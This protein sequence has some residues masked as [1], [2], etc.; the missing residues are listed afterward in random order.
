MPEFLPTHISGCQVWLDASDLNYLFS[1]KD[2]SFPVSVDGD[3]VGY[4]GDK[5]GND[6]NFTN[7]Y[8]SESNRPIYVESAYHSKPAIRFNGTS[9]YLTL[10]TPRENIEQTVFIVASKPENAGATNQRLLTQTRQVSTLDYSR[11]YAPFVVQP[12]TRTLASTIDSNTVY[13]GA[14]NFSSIQSPEEFSIFCDRVTQTNYN[15]IRNGKFTSAAAGTLSFRVSSS[16]TRMG[17]NIANSFSGTTSGNYFAGDVSEL[18]IYNRYL[19]NDERHIVEYYLANKWN[20]YDANYICAIKN[21]NWSDYLTWSASAVPTQNTQVYS[22]NFSVEIDQN[23]NVPILSNATLSPLVSGSNGK[24]LLNNPYS[25]LTSP[26]GIIGS[27]DH[28]LISNLSGLTYSISGNFTGPV[29][30][31]NGSELDLTVYGNVRATTTKNCI[32]LDNENCNLTIYGNVTGGD[33]V[34]GV[35][36]LNSSYIKVYGNVYGGTNTNGHGL[37]IEN[38]KFY[39]Y[40]NVYAG[41]TYNG[42]CHGISA[43]ETLGTP[44]IFVYGNIYGTTAYGLKLFQNGNLELNGDAVA[45]NQWAAINSSTFLL[46]NITINGSLIHGPNGTQPIYAPTYFVKPAIYNSTTLNP[47]NSLVNLTTYSND[48]VAGGYVATRSTIRPNFSECPLPGVSASFIAEDTST[49]THYI[50]KTYTAYLNSFFNTFLTIYAKKQG[51]QYISLYLGEVSPSNLRYSKAIFDLENGVV[52]DMNNYTSAGVTRRQALTGMESVG[53]GWYRC[54]L[55][56]PF[57]QAEVTVHIAPSNVP[58]FASTTQSVVS[59]TG[60][61]LSGVLICGLHIYPGLSAIDGM[62]YTT[63]PYVSTGNA[64]GYYNIYTNDSVDFFYPD[65]YKLNYVPQASSV[66]IGTIYGGLTSLNN[67]EITIVETLTGTM[68]IPNSVTVAY[69]VPVGD[70]VGSAMLSKETLLNIWKSDVSSLT[71]NDGL[72]TRLAKTLTNAQ[73]GETMQSLDNL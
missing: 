2:G 51:R 18:I 4:W 41:R 58:K 5:S 69:G 27:T 63:I 17:A 71:A 52:T 64:P 36:N 13:T 72:F 44:N 12:N 16:M 50:G 9:S 40:G 66:E 3:P 47:N 21:G 57:T 23:I 1:F 30:F 42:T 37:R 6:L 8:A 67:E 28:C 46:N 25:I 73:A 32:E 38:G 59:Y 10:G 20:V 15:N 53:D 19:T 33:T 54:I 61:T 31:Q 11:G 43:G 62:D 45:T 29:L 7:D 14:I 56:C 48:F 39:I 55:E 70:T 22:N 34:S 65:S 24:F 68:V 60:N 49:N 26:S 35:N